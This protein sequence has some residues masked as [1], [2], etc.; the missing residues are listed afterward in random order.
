MES[1]NIYSMEKGASYEKVA[2]RYYAPYFDEK[3]HE[4]ILE[5]LNEVRSKH[6]IDFE[7]IEVSRETEREIYRKDF[8]SRAKILSGRIGGS[9]ARALRSRRGHVYLRGTIALVLKDRLEWFASY[10]DPLYK[11][12]KSFDQGAPTTIG[13]LRMILEKGKPL[14]EEI[15]GRPLIR[16]AEHAQIVDLFIDSNELKLIEKP[17]REV[18]IGKEIIIFD[19]YGKKKEVGKKIVDIVCKTSEATWVIEAKQYLNAEAI[20][21][22]LVY[23]EL[24]QKQH[25][26]EKVRCG[27]V[28]KYAD[29]ELYEIGK[30]YI[31]EIFVLRKLTEK[32]IVD[33]HR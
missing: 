5:L 15:M 17:E 31:D 23:K 11:K 4:K 16:Q 2:L 12:W 20:G 24:Y 1:I 29:K 3:I 14:V 32:R 9:V 19:K 22:A 6:D 7:I 21:Q 13:I 27:V 25:P 28:C 10:T 18:S 8:V 26:Q 33:W 30:R